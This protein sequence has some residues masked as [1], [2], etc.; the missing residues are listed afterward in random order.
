MPPRSATFRFVP[1]ARITPDTPRVELVSVRV[2]LFPLIGRVIRVRWAV[3]RPRVHYRVC[4]RQAHY[5]GLQ[6]F[7]VAQLYRAT[8]FGARMSESLSQDSAIAQA[9][10][11][12]RGFMI[13]TD[14]DRGGWILAP[15]DEAVAERLLAVP[16]PSVAEDTTINP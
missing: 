5:W 14:P 3:S 16:I 12:R 7:S 4:S 6:G 1:D 15:H 2:K 11:L 10:K 9:I 13:G 8:E